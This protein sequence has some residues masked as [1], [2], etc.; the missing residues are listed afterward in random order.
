MRLIMGRINGHY[1]RNIIEN[2][3]S[4][5][6]EVLAAVAYAVDSSLLF[7][8]CWANKIP[9][10]YYGRLDEGIAVSVA[11]LTDFLKKKSPT[12]VCRLVQHHHAK[13]IWWRGVGM[14]IGSANLTESAWYK[15]VESGC[16][17][18]EEEINDDMAGDVRELFATLE[19]HSTPLTE[20]LLEEMKKRALAL[21]KA[22]PDAKEFWNSPSFKKWPGLVQTA[23]EKVMDKRRQSFL[24]EWHSTLQELRDIGERVS[25]QEN[26]P[27]WISNSAPAGAQADQFLHAHYYQR[28]FEGKKAHY[29][30][31]YEENRARRDLALTETINWWRTLPKAPS[32]EDKMLNTTAPFLQNALSEAALAGMDESIFQD[33]CFGVH[34][35]KDYARRVPNRAVGLPENETRYTI[36][37]KVIALAHRIWNAKSAG[38][39]RVDELLRSILY[40]GSDEQL[41]ERLWRA[42][43]DPAWKI[44]GLG[45]S[46]LGE[47]VGWALPDRFPPRN[48]R[49]SKALRSLGYDVTIHVE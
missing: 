46:A 3:A 20:E 26:R 16:F 27:A 34:S 31:F 25:R 2:A 1:L 32:D 35:I 38:G 37:Q 49:T 15:N 40:G 13:V 28:T 11:I 19:A 24:E 14:Y 33:I 43:S 30:E 4:D 42:V 29:A 47:L 18:P 17:F 12:F 45:I 41:P 9:L 21:T 39:Y 48:G 22:K 8:W 7:D 36:P 10:K 5:T 23:P 6:E 44:E